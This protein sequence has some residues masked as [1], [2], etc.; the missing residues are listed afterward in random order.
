MRQRG[1]RRDRTKAGVR[2]AVASALSLCLLLPAVSQASGDEDLAMQ[3]ANPIA[4]LISVPFQNNWERDIGPQGDGKRYRLNIQPVV[5]FDLGPDWN[6]I[7]RVIVPVVSQTDVFPGAGSQ[8]G[9]GDTLASLFFSPKRPTAGGMLWGAGPV[10]LLP[11]GTDDLLTGKK[12]GLGPTGVVLTQAGPWTYGVLGN[13]VWSV[14]GADS[15][16]DISAS[17]VQPFLIYTTPTA[18][19]VGV[20]AEATYDW[21]QSESSVPVTVFAGRVLRIGGMPVQIIGGPRYFVSHFDNGPKGWGARLSVTLM[22][23]R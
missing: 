5:P 8:F 1:A 13:H 12:W 9:L 22:F 16:P 21:K 20:Q 17:F 10:F 3:L 19:S 2:C 4:S 6:L 18:W 7:S 11:T 15:R 14:A 23:P